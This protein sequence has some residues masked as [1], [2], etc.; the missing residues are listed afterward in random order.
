MEASSDGVGPGP[1]LKASNLAK[2]T[3]ELNGNSSG[4]KNKKHM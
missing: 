1:L 2:K 3:E 4:R